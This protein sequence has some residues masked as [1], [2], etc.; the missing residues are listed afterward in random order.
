VWAT[1]P[2]STFAV[3]ESGVILRSTGPADAWTPTKVQA[4]FLFGVWGT[5]ATD[6]FTVGDPGV[7]YHGTP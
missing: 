5:S 6:V 3:G 7:I 1:A 2:S 4:D